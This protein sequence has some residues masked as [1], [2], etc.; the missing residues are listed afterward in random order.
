MTGV[1]QSLGNSLLPIYVNSTKSLDN[2]E[3]EKA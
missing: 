1:S 2:K 3:V